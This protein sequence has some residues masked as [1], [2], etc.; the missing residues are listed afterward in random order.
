MAETNKN[1][2][3]PTVCASLIGCGV[4]ILLANWSGI[5]WGIDFTELKL[6]I[7]GSIPA[8][9]IAINKFFKFLYER[10]L[11]GA[12]KR[13]F[14]KVNQDKIERLR[15]AL[16]DPLID[17]LSKKEFHKQY[18]EAIQAGINIKDPNITVVSTK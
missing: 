7:I 6:L 17:D 15:N 8:I 13:T 5:L 10:F 3:I 1:Q 14:D 16:N 9:T 2:S 4:S 12:E 18:T 11:M